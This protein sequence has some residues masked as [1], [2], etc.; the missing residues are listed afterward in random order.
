MWHLIIVTAAKLDSNIF[1]MS[2][3]KTWGVL[4]K[5]IEFFKNINLQG[6][7]KHYFLRVAFMK[8]VITAMFIFFNKYQENNPLYLLTWVEILSTC[9]PIFIYVKLENQQ[10]I[11]DQRSWNPGSISKVQRATSYLP[12]LRLI[13]EL[14]T[15]RDCDCDFLSQQM[16]C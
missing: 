6:F 12:S 8:I 2:H 13:S 16:G 1:K 9:R 5:S 4:K 14:F 15:W 10:H 7:A 11:H 3:V